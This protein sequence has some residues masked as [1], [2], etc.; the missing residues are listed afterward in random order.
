[1]DDGRKQT[2]D[3]LVNHVMK[4]HDHWR[5]DILDAMNEAYGTNTPCFRAGWQEALKHA[6]KAV[7]ETNDLYGEWVVGEVA[8]ILTR[9]AMR[10]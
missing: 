5:A 7:R 10:G 4:H 2:V 6:K 1:M 3:H 9:K 8:S